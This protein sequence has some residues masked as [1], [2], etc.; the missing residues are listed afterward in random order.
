MEHRCAGV[1]LSLLYLN[2]FFYRALLWI[3][4]HSDDLSMTGEKVGVRALANGMEVAGQEGEPAGQGAGA[5]ET[6]S[7]LP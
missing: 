4:H 5:L 6:E 2:Q 7:I 3:A 1:L